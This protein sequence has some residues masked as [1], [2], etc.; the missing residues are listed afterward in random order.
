MN[1]RIGCF[2]MSIRRQNEQLIPNLAVFFDVQCTIIISCG[3]DYYK[4]GTGFVEW[5]IPVSF[6]VIMCR[7]FIKEGAEKIK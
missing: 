4:K 6:F 5:T 1:R 3:A 7:N 2:V